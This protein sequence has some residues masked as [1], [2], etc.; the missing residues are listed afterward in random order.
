MIL[1][2]PTERKFFEQC[3][4]EVYN[5]LMRD[6]GNTDTSFVVPLFR[7][8]DAYW[9]EV[10][11]DYSCIPDEVLQ[12]KI[13][14]ELVCFKIWLAWKALLADIPTATFAEAKAVAMCYIPGVY[15]ASYGYQR[16]TKGKEDKTL[17]I[18]FRVGDHNCVHLAEMEGLIK[19]GLG[20]KEWWSKHKELTMY[21]YLRDIKLA[22][23]YQLIKREELTP[24]LDNLIYGQVALQEENEV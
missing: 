13:G 21:R 16:V 9:R 12:A 3:T 7:R 5:T 2:S 18:K 15:H 20:L 4:E 1:L 22:L 23:F 11:L 17:A 10:R 6:A 19:Q 24:Y 14:M 8:I